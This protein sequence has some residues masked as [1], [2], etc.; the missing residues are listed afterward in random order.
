MSKLNARF[1]SLFAR[2]AGSLCAAVVVTA[3]AVEVAAAPVGYVYYLQTFGD[4]TVTCGRDESSGRDNC[5]LS[6]PPPD[7]RG[8][9]QIEI[10]DGQGDNDAVIV[11]VRGALMP[12]SPLYLRVDGKSP[13]QTQPNRFGEGRWNGQEAEAVV[14]ELSSGQ[15]A[16]VRSFSGPPPSPRDAFFSLERF[17]DALADLGRRTSGKPPAETAQ[18]TPAEPQPR[19]E[20]TPPMTMPPVAPPPVAQPAPQPPP[21]VPAQTE[22]QP[23]PP[24][25]QQT[26]QQQPATREEPAPPPRQQPVAAGEAVAIL[27]EAHVGRARLTTNVVNREPVDQ[28]GSRVDI[29]A[30]G[31]DFVYFFTEIRGMAGKTVTH[32]WQYGGNVVAS[33][34]FQIGSDRWRVYS[35]KGINGGQTGP[36]TVTAVGPNGSELARGT[37]TAE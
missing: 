20:A 14:A 15:R 31:E 24:Q 27:D 26:A 21:Q 25:P 35:R 10:G 29:P 16:V 17:N 33:V 1:R 30:S 7:R 22:P 8:E 11:R 37:F 18:A 3:P 19:T 2:L 9:S 6:A 36:W 34:P 13:H 28:L 4:W 5:T 32:R 12:E 23:A